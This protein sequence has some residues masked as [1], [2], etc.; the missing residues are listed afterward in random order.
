MPDERDARVV[1]HAQERRSQM[2]G[3]LP[4]KRPSWWFRRKMGRTNGF[5][6]KDNKTLAV[7]IASQVSLR[8]L[9]ISHRDLH[10]TCSSEANTRRISYFSTSRSC[11]HY[12][13]FSMGPGRNHLMKFDSCASRCQRC[14]PSSQTKIDALCNIHAARLHNNLKHETHLKRSD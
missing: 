14:Q 4:M 9:L 10:S 12:D 2:R 3:W 11:S 8:C 7:W 5:G 13:S 6:G 1:A